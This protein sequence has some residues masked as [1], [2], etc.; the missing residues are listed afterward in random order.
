M[1]AVPRFWRL[2][3]L[4]FPHQQISQPS[5]RGRAHQAFLGGQETERGAGE[6]RHGRQSKTRE[7]VV[8]LS[9]TAFLRSFKL[10][11]S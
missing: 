1:P 7:V 5:G 10:A 3:P 6:A 2:R 11:F 9:T 8:D 4:V